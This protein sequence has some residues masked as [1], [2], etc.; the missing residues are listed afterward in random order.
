MLYYNKID[1]SQRIDP[2]KSNNSKECMIFHYWFFNHGLEFQDSVCN[3]CHNLT[4][5]CLSISDITIITVK[6]V[7]YCCIIHNISKSEAINLF[8]K[9]MFLKSWIYIYIYI[10]IY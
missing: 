5:L 8:K 3:S 10:Y 6:N 4:M 1:I 2:V 9:I 7:D